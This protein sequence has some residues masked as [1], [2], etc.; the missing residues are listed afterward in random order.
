M[1]YT[2]IQGNVILI[3]AFSEEPQ[4]ALRMGGGVILEESTLIRIETSDD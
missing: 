4:H 3:E 2:A 1:I